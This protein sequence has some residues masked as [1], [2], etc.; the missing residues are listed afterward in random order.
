MS[1]SVLPEDVLRDA[2]S[3]APRPYELADL[4]LL[5]SGAYAPLTGFLVRA[6]LVALARTGRLADGTP[7]PVAVTL[8]IPLDLA[9]RLNPA[10]PARRTVVLTDLEGAP[11]AAIEA[12]DVWRIADNRYG[13]G[14]PVQR[15]GDGGHG[16]FQ[17]LRR[18]PAEVKALLPPG[19]V[20]GVIADRPLHRPQLAQIA[21]AARTLAAHLLIMIPVSGH[22]PDGLPPEALVRA[23]FAARDR[24]PPA[25]VVA[26]PL[27][28]HG[29][30]MR[31]ALLRSR[32]AAAYGVTHVLSTGESLSGAGLRVLVPRELAYDNRDGQWRWRD[33][34]PP[35]NRRLAMTPDEIDDLL[36][37]GFPLPEWHTPPA[38]AKELARVRPPRRHR[39]LVLFFTGLSGSGKSTIA[40]NLADA[41]RETGERTVTLLDGDVVRR[42]LTAGLGFSKADRDRNVRRIGWVAAEVGRHR[43]MAVACPI[44]P[45][46]AARTAVRRMAAEAGAGFLLVHVA[47]PLEVC[48]RRDRKGLYARARAGQ[49]RG[50]TGIDDPYEEPLDAEL[51]IDTSTMSVAE[52]VEMVLGY[53]VENGWVEPKLS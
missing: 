11:I 17:R 36:D 9:E 19:R 23:V 47:T 33:D 52:A 21:H 1:G 39:G 20:L 53:L 43:G 2:P 5:L 7:W 48:E 26:V 27:M 40:R 34:I 44:A 18:S 13:V 24:M 15:M 50:M 38:V 29:D 14:G 22:G 45:Y 35:R 51:T 28:P 30:E 42:E 41:L 6:D 25:T 8:E 31:D 49:L 32:V 4:E 3:F 46:E 16:P 37:R 10:D 12:R